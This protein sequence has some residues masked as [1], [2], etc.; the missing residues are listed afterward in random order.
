M[1]VMQ[2]QLAQFEK[3]LAEQQGPDAGDQEPGPTD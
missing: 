3:A 1:Q 2:R